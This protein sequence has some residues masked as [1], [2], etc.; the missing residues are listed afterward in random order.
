MVAQAEPG[1]TSP[2]GHTKI[3]A[4]HKAAVDENHLQTSRKE[5]PQLET[6]RRNRDEKGGGRRGVL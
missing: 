3:T 5:F 1:L 2:V 4:A 6:Q